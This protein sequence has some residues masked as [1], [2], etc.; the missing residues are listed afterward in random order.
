MKKY[1]KPY[2]VDKATEA[3][4]K[5]IASERFDGNESMALR[6]IISEHKERAENEAFSL[7]NVVLP[8][9]KVKELRNG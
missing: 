5:A 2:S 7:D 1:S 3:Y 4:I 9:Y 6:A 8:A